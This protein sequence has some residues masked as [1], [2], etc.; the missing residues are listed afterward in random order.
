M[1]ITV[2][3]RDSNSPNSDVWVTVVG[4]IDALES[5]SF[6]AE[7]SVQL[8]A[9]PASLVL[10]LEKVDYLDSSGLAIIV[11]TWRSQQTRNRRFQLVMPASETAKRIFDLAGFDGVFDVIDSVSS[12][13]RDVA[14]SFTT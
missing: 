1:E 10:D 13:S 2:T 14:T 12:A 11:R 3:S 5:S 7:M 8:A 6:S 9:A 4:R